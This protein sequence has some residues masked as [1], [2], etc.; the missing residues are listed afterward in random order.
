MLMSRLHVPPPLL[1]AQARSPEYLMRRFD[2][3]HVITD[4]CANGKPH[5]D[6]TVNL[7]P[8]ST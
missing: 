3:W 4:Q 1:G 7:T 6:S 8:L 2:S 5:L